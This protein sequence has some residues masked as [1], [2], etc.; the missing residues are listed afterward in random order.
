MK[1][2]AIVMILALAA[3]TAM[4]HDVLKVNYTGARPSITDFAWAFLFTP[5]DEEDECDGEATGGIMDALE[6]Y[7]RGEAQDEYATLLVDERNGF[8]RYE[9]RYPDD[10]VLSVI[11]MCYW[12]EA[13]GKHKLFVCSRWF[14]KNG[15]P[16]LGQYD[17]MIFYRYTNATKSMAMCE[18]PGFEVQYYDTTYSLPRSGKDIIMTKWDQDGRA[19]EHILHWNGHRFNLMK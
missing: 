2:N 5:D 12:N 6:R 18:A 3:M 10:N 14:Y 7:R 8:I 1:R 9:W 13:D 19:T 15:K 16:L 4:A 17:G 11:E